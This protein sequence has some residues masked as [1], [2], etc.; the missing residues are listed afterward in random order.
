MAAG[1]DA[2]IKQKF[3]SNSEGF[4]LLSKTRQELASSIPQNPQAAQAEQNPAVVA[5]KEALEKLD[6]IKLQKE[7]VQKDGIAMHDNLNA[8]EELMQVN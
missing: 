8:V 1:T 2:Q 6:E 3:E 4:K 5:I 7:G